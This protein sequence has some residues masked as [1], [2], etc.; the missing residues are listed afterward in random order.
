MNRIINPLQIQ[1]SA[2][3]ISYKDSF[4]TGFFV[5]ENLVITT[6]HV[7][8]EKKIDSRKIAV[9]KNTGSKAKAKV[10]AYSQ[11]FDLCILAVDQSND[12]YLPIEACEIRTKDNWETYGFPYAAD[13]AGIRFEGLISHEKNNAIEDFVLSSK[14]I[15]ANYDFDGL[16]GGPVVSNGVV[17]GIIIK[18]LDSN[19]GSISVKKASRFLEKSK[20]HIQHQRSIS[21][22]PEEFVEDLKTSVPNYRVHSLL[23]DALRSNESWVLLHGTPGS[24]KTLSVAAFSSLENDISVIG[25]YFIKIPSDKKPLSLR[26]SPKYFLEW[27]EESISFTLTGK[28]M[29][30]E[31][32]SIEQ[33]VERLA[34]FFISLGDYFKNSKKVGIIFIDGLDELE[35]VDS[36]LNIIPLSLPKNIKIVLS[37]TSKE[38]LP[39]NI[40]NSIPDECQ[41]L[42][43]ALDLQKCEYFLHNQLKGKNLS[44]TQI[45]LLSQKSE[46]HPLYLRYLGNYVLESGISSDKEEFDIWVNNIPSIG[47]DIKVYYESIWDNLYRDSNILWT[48]LIL[49]QLRQSVEIE[50]LMKILPKEVKHNFYSIFPEIKHL[51]TEE[52]KIEIYHSSFKKFIAMK[53]PLLLKDAH[54]EILTFCQKNQ[55]TEYSVLNYIHHQLNG[56]SRHDA[57][58]KCNQK[59]ADLLATN[60]I[61]PD[62]ILSDIKQVI[63]ASID[64]NEVSELIRLLLLFQRIEF[65]YDS[66]FVEYAENI[67]L[68]LIANKKFKEALIY[69][70]RD[71]VLLVSDSDAIL[72]LQ[73]FYEADRFNEARVLSEAINARFRKMFDDRTTSGEGIPVDALASHA[74]SKILATNE[75]FEPAYRDFMRFTLHLQELQNNEKNESS[76]N[77]QTILK[78][79][80]Y[81]SSWNLAYIERRFG[82]SFDPERVS[83]TLKKPLDEKWTKMIAIAKLVL[84]KELT[85]YNLTVFESEISGENMSLSD[86]IESLIDQY[87]YVHEK[88]EL[89]ILINALIADSKDSNLVKSLIN[90]YGEMPPD[91][92]AIRKTNGV[93]FDFENYLNLCFKYL[94]LGYINKRDYA[95]ARSKYFN[96]SNWENLIIDIVQHA[97]F[98]EGQVLCLKSNEDSKGLSKK[99]DEVLSFIDRLDFTLDERSYWERSYLLPEEIIPELHVKILRICSLLNDESVEGFI[100]RIVQNPNKQLGLYS[101]GFINSLYQISKELLV[102]GFNSKLIKSVIDELYEFVIIHIQNRWT[103]TQ[104]LLR[105]SELYALVGEYEKSELT[106]QEVLNTSM[107]PSWYKEAQ[108]DLINT[109]LSYVK[110]EK[111]G[112]NEYIS[113]FASQLD[114]ASGE[115]TFQRYVR[116]EKETFVRSLHEFGSPVHSIEYFK[117]EIIPSPKNL[118]FNAEKDPLDAPRVGDGY[119]LG[120][121][122][123]VEQSVILKIIQTFD[124]K[125]PYL[126]WA[127]CNVFAI[128]DDTFRYIQDY[129]IQ[130]GE[131]LV[132]LDNNKSPHIADVVEDLCV[133]VRSS[134]I[135]QDDTRTFLNYLVGNISSTVFVLLKE[136]LTEEEFSPYFVEKKSEDVSHSETVKNDPFDEFNKASEKLIEEDIPQMINI[137]LGIF[138]EQN[139]SPFYSNYSHGSKR[140]RRNLKSIIKR[141]DDVL[142]S[143]KNEILR[144]PEEPW[145]VAKELLWFLEGKL[146]PELSDD[147]YE[148]VCGHFNLIVRPDEKTQEKYNWLNEEI[149]DDRSIDHL[150]SDLLIWFLNHPVESIR[151]K[152]ADS[153]HKLLVYDSEIVFNQVLEHCLS[154]N[155]EISSE[156]CSLILK[157]MSESNPDEL[158]ALFKKWPVALNKLSEIDHFT[159][160]KNFLDIGVNLSKNG[161]DLLYEV[162]ESSYEESITS[163][164]EAFLDED[165]LLPIRYYIDQLETLNIINKVFCQNLLNYI[166][167][168]STSLSL[169]DYV[170]SDRYLR[171]S[172]YE[173]PSYEGRYYYFLRHALNVALCGQVPRNQLEQ[174][175]DIINS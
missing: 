67:A 94:C 30:K 112:S 120:G 121:R 107:G 132:E 10:I 116:Y 80:E 163:T 83:E 148:A 33:R 90:E 41:I 45:Q 119:A 174:V 110:I 145:V 108:L 87:G 159:I 92:L 88:D 59:W 81:I 128:N 147:I 58:A 170:K 109:V 7:F 8:F 169:T 89:K 46:G 152:T 64:F 65:R 171:R 140:A 133:L 24:G 2:V 139:L 141:A 135:N 78:L 68:S 104:E 28:V 124:I 138:D 96:P 97:C 12:T 42:V 37:C 13:D 155:P 117:Q 103:R 57:I 29:P 143:L 125:S 62:L 72:F 73:L 6:F 14:D 11:E 36:F 153:I 98:I 111:N 27:L 161:D 160:K 166:G 126:K 17:V 38:I 31:S 77:Y 56:N 130:F 114:C 66:V 101:E 34:S 168:N 102:L 115:M 47:G 9:H 137:A 123:I 19:L 99:C 85:R 113:Q 162:M 3:K 50:L 44:L 54:D 35:Q 150:I 60:H 136:N 52:R 173:A 151:H 40:K 18:Q 172:F 146:N 23:K 49:S 43:T 158:Q 71:K 82:L 149:E 84:D 127:L 55:E 26:T 156:S 175:Y 165:Y 106:Y 15:D 105:I 142:G 4:G 86:C 144:L 51:F 39:S 118:I 21:D 157:S 100:N 75:D 167:E 22:I 131:I 93:D 16:S 25:K 134:E 164:K 32:L 91:D 48:I 79:R 95:P 154:N 122:N 61:E 70:V 1:L 20:I 69:I 53:T 129:G 76:E 5:S 74:Q 63:E